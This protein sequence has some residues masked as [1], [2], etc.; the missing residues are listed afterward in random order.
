MSGDEEGYLCS[1]C[2]APVLRFGDLCTICREGAEEEAAEQSVDDY[3]NALDDGCEDE[4]PE[5][6]E[7]CDEWEPFKEAYGGLGDLGGEG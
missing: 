4:P 2:N 6:A 5:L 7:D 3:W 1:W